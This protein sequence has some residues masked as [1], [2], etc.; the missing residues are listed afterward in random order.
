MD[1]NTF[2]NLTAA[3]AEYGEAV[4]K[5]YRDKLIYHDNVATGNLLRSVQYRVNAN[6]TIYEVTLSLADYWKYIETGVHAGG[7]MPPP[8]KI[9][10]W[11][12]AKPVL[13]RPDDR[14]RVPKPE[15]LAWAIA[16]KIQ[17]D[18]IPAPAEPPLAT[19]LD[20]VNRQYRAKIAA[21]FQADTMQ[22]L[23]LD[24]MNGSPFSRLP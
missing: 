19:T 5:L 16:K 21:A 2:P 22:L 8:S 6:G 20:E 11:I 7:R 24:A 17:R 14:G 4:Q 18:G 23:R 13:P 15:Q 3:L 9:L 12:V 10:E 1:D